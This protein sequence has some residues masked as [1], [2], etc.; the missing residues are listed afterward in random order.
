MN[1]KGFTLIEV[2]F[3]IAALG[4]ICAVLL[5]LF[6]LAGNTNNRAANIQNAQVAVA[7]TAEIL[8][9]AETLEDGLTALSLIP[10]A[11]GPAGQY[12]LLHSG[13][14]VVVT[15]S[16]EPG[17]YPG[18]LYSLSIDAEQDGKKLAGIET[19]KY[20]GGRTYG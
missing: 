17:E 20:D 2:L 19:A 14:T 9:G 13:F 8:A 15:I 12:R 10:P 3:S 7:S 6:L 18:T 1:K 4:I 11:S 5:K 16:E